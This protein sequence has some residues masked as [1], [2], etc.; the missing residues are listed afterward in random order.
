MK[1]FKEHATKL[2]RINTFSKRI[3][4]EW[5]GLPSK[6]VKADTVETFKEKLDEHWES[7][8]YDHPFD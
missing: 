8:M 4:H 6:V 1:I 2:P 3:V 5:N 7:R